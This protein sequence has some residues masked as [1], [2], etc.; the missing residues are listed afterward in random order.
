MWQNNQYHPIPSRPVP[1][2]SLEGQNVLSAILVGTWFL[3]KVQSLEKCAQ[4]TNGLNDGIL[5]NLFIA[6][7]CPGVDVRTIAGAVPVP[8]FKIHTQAQVLQQSVKHFQNSRAC[9]KGN[10]CNRW[11]GAGKEGRFTSILPG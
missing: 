8:Q 2:S 9:T 3:A 1:R 11:R 4:L 10:K 7:L 5:N 6:F